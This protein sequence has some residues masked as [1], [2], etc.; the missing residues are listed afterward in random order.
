MSRK[1]STRRSRP[2]FINVYGWLV[3]RNSL[4][5]GNDT[6]G[7]NLNMQG[8][9]V[10]ICFMVQERNRYSLLWRKLNLLYVWSPSKCHT[11]FATEHLS[12]RQH[13]DPYKPDV[14]SW[15]VMTAPIL[16]SRESA[17]F[18]SR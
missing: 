3:G 6:L 5:K 16:I 15:M 14:V 12:R 8:H 11:M 1:V 10:R 9:H 7:L 4:T 18:S 17:A 13:A 2:P